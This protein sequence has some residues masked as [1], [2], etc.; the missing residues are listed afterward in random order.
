MIRSLSTTRDAK[1]LSRSMNG[2]STVGFE[3][4]RTRFRMTPSTGLL[5]QCSLCRRRNTRMLIWMI[6]QPHASWKTDSPTTRARKRSIKLGVK[7]CTV[8]FC[9]ERDA[10]QGSKTLLQKK[11]L[12]TIIV[13]SHAFRFEELSKRATLKHRYLYAERYGLSRAICGWVEFSGEL[14]K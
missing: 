3:Q 9:V 5:L 11:F 6:F 1:E 7:R 13:F 12:G 2:Q 14:S 4:R 10:P 8:S